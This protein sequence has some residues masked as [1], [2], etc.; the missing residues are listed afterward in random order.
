MFLGVFSFTSFSSTVLLLYSPSSVGH[1]RRYL[2][3]KT[4]LSKDSSPSGYEL[5]PIYLVA[6]P[7]YLFPFAS[8]CLVLY[9]DF[10]IFF[11]SVLSIPSSIDNCIFLGNN[12]RESI[13]DGGTRDES[14]FS[15]V[16]SFFSFVFFFYPIQIRSDA[17]KSSTSSR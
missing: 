8:F 13:V 17:D 14:L 4:T 12:D 9:R 7:I 16:S 11:Y 2:V 1:L 5:S 3:E 10:D 15:F 6:A